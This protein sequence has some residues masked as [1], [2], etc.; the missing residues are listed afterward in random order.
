M[1]KDSYYI[2]TNNFETEHISNKIELN[3]KDE[4]IGRHINQSIYYDEFEIFERDYLQGPQYTYNDTVKFSME[5]IFCEDDGVILD[6]EYDKFRDYAPDSPRPYSDGVAISKTDISHIRDFFNTVI[7]DTPEEEYNGIISSLNNNPQLS[8]GFKFVKSNSRGV[9]L[10]NKDKDYL[11]SKKSIIKALRISHKYIDVCSSETFINANSDYFKGIDIPAFLAVMERTDT[12]NYYDLDNLK[13]QARNRELFPTA[14]KGYKKLLS[15]V[16]EN[17]IDEVNKWIGYAAVVKLDESDNDTPLFNA[18]K[19]NNVEIVKLLLDNMACIAQRYIDEEH[20]YFYPFTDAI[21]NKEYEIQKLFA[22][23]IGDRFAN[24]D[25]KNN[26]SDESLLSY[27]QSK[28]SSCNDI[29]A[30][31]IFLPPIKEKIELDI[32]NFSNPLTINEIKSLTSISGAKINWDVR[33][34]DVAYKEDR[35]LCFEMLEQGCLLDAVEYF[36]DKDDYEL[37]E[38][39]I[40]THKLN[41]FLPPKHEALSIKICDKGSRWYGALRKY[42]EQSNFD[43]FNINYLNKMYEEDNKKFYEFVRNNNVDIS[44]LLPVNKHMKELLDSNNFDGFKKYV[45]DNNISITNDFIKNYE[46]VFTKQEKKQQ[47]DL[48][49][50]ILEH[51]DGT[52]Y[53]K[54]FLCDMDKIKNIGETRDY[55]TNI[56]LKYYPE[57][58]ALK[59]VVD[60]FGSKPQKPTRTLEEFKEVFDACVFFKQEKVAL[61]IMDKAYDLIANSECEEATS[62]WKALYGML[63]YLIRQY[64]NAKYISSLNDEEKEKARS[65]I[66]NAI[67]QFIRTKDLDKI[68]EEKGDYSI[69]FIGTKQGLIR[70]LES[71]GLYHEEIKE[72]LEKGSN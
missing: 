43:E 12:S 41:W 9:Y 24:K 19:N 1:D 59:V 71:Q 20:T 54:Y 18:V 62:K 46:D 63:Y 27:I 26:Y 16:K 68:Y 69:T 2:C 5:T 51:R 72:I 52:T 10:K 45:V 58:F 29:K 3:W 48:I 21:D 36:V 32:S 42:C 50:F 6:I 11:V 33:N 7:I 44:R 40:S 47:D 15:A 23:I 31:K 8:N 25:H 4:Y 39:T 70:E 35:N 56:I 38:K 14:E 30:I 13:R 57:D 65:I 60:N 67:H 53:L 55:L 34:L 22:K 37:F 61:A 28:L 64:G 49:N 66:K 17:D